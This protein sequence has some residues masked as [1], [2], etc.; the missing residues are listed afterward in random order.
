MTIEG[1]SFELV[2]GI[3]SEAR[4]HGFESGLCH[5]L[6]DFGQYT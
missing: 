6:C 3:D 1:L 2:Q 5:L 4:L